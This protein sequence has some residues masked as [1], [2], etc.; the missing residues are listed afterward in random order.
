MCNN[1][2]IEEKKFTSTIEEDILRK[3]SKSM[4]EELKLMG[5]G[6]ELL[7]LIRIF[8]SITSIFKLIGKHVGSIVGGFMDMFAYTAMLIPI[9]KYYMSL[10]SM[11]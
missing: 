8:K 5:I 2:F 10:E 1:L 4:L 7:K 6:I 9:M 11:T 3:D